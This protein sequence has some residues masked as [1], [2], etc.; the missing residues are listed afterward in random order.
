MERLSV[1]SGFA[2]PP[3]LFPAADPAQFHTLASIKILVLHDICRGFRNWG[4]IRFVFG[5][6]VSAD[7]L[8]M[9]S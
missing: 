3:L 1:T 5:R 2:P 9:V 7:S 6:G 8:R 4:T